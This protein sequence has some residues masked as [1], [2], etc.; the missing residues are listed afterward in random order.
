MADPMLT[1]LCAICHI[2]VPRYKCPRC[3]LRSCSLAC[4]KKHKAWSE[5]SGT[6]DPT[7]YL[8][9]SRLR[10]PAGVDHDYNFLHGIERSLERA[11]R[12]LVDERR[13]VQA[14]ELRPVTVQ[15]VRWKTG[16]D[17]RKRRVLVTRL[18]REAKT[19]QFERS[20]AH[21]LRKLNVEVICV[22]TGMTRQKENYTTLNKRTSRINWQVEWFVV[23]DGR[24]EAT[25]GEAANATRFLSKVMDDVP[26]HEAY[27]TMLDEQQAA[28]RRQAKKDGRAT[29][30]QTMYY[31][32]SPES[33]CWPSPATLQDPQTGLWFAYTGPSIDM[34]P[35]EKQHEYQFFLGRPQTRRPDRRVTVSPLQVTDCFRD[36]LANTRVLEFPT[37]IVLRSGQM[38]PETYTLGPKDTLLPGPAGPHGSGGGKRKDGP[39]GGGG[40]GGGGN[41]GDRAAKKRKGEDEEGEVDEDGE[42][43]SDGGGG[44]L[45][46][47][48]VIDEQSMGEEDDEDDEDDD[49]SSSGTSSASEDE[50]DE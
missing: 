36:I 33:R 7:T 24:V 6:R 47:G 26:L 13:L 18:L 3:G 15:E 43:G 39:A 49:T 17:G 29:E 14:E 32:R 12:V 37:I 28:K 38:L 4:T 8:P 25:Q 20:L 5:C 44:G 48:D 19:R 9:P 22:P 45:V 1:S 35:E 30:D 46:E 40:G 23:D 10:T 31:G 2:A 42:E 50:G 41:G 16:R 34:W 27:R 11:E 21:R